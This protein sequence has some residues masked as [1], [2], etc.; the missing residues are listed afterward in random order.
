MVLAPFLAEVL[1]HVEAA[2]GAGG[3]ACAATAS[4]A[5][6]AAADAAA[7]HVARVGED[8]VLLLA[9]EAV[10]HDATGIEVVDAQVLDELR[11]VGGLSVAEVDVAYPALHHVSFYLKVEHELLLAVVDARFA[12]EV[13]LTL[14]VLDALDDAGRQVFGADFAVVAEE[15][16][17]AHQQTVNLTSVHLDGAVVLNFNARNLAKQFLQHRAFGD[18]EVLSVN[19]QRVL[20][21][22]YVG[23]LCFDD[24]LF[25]QDG[26]A[27]QLDGVQTNGFCAP[28]D[29]EGLV[30]CAVADVRDADVVIARLD[31]LLHFEVSVVKRS[32]ALD[33]GAVGQRH[34]LDGSL[35]HRFARLV[36]HYC[37][38]HVHRALLL[39]RRGKT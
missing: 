30:L 7:C 3:E 37:T 25:Q 2:C 15:L 4:S 34:P 28:V 35:R 38:L 19:H 36:V 6:S 39:C 20:H 1:G 18:A 17:A 24:S 13:A 14:V 26:V 33:E 16:L 23:H 11:L 27:L 22:L 29:G 21:H 12:A 31:A 8:G 5:S 32:D 9:L 10:H